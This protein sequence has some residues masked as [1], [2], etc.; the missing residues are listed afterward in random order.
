MW[1]AFA[2]A[3]YWLHVAGWCVEVRGDARHWR[4]NTAKTRTHALGRLGQWA[5][6]HHDRVWRTL[7][8]Y[9]AGFRTQIPA[10]GEASAPT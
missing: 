10:I 8:R 5:L 7:L 9:Q 2:W 1:R 3:Y 6:E 4:A